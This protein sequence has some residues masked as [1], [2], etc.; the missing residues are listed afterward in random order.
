MLREQFSGIIGIRVLQSCGYDCESF[1]MLENDK[2]MPMVLFGE[3]NIF[4]L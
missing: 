2:E 1:N 3:K 4:D